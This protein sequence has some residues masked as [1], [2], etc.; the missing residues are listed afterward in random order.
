MAYIINLVAKYGF[1][2]MYQTKFENNDKVVTKNG[3]NNI[4]KCKCIHI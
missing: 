3:R 4:T 1:N 2:A